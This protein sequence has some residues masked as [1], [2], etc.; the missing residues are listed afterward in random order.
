MKR[1]GFIEGEEPKMTPLPEEK[2]KENDKEKEKAAE[3]EAVK[4][5]E[6]LNLKEETPKNDGTAANQDK[7][8]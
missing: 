7:G 2:E 4:A 5:M 3:D 8:G 1:V 6:S